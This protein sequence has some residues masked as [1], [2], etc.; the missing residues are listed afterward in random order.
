MSDTKESN[1]SV[2][3]PAIKQRLQTA[4][5]AYNYGVEMERERIIK[6]LEP[7]VARHYELGLDASVAYLEEIIVR[8]KGE[9]K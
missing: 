4:E 5:L 7:E 1:E 6:L 8:I 3:T 2:I 9:Q